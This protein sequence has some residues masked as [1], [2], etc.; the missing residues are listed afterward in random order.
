MGDISQISSY[1]IY[2]RT[3]GSFFAFCQQNI[4]KKISFLSYFLIMFLDQTCSELD[5]VIETL[6]AQNIWKIQTRKVSWYL[7][8]NKWK[9]QHYFGRNMTNF[10]IMSHT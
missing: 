4:E 3:F 6:G 5:E 7:E 10:C 2:E 9:I 1:Q 8:D